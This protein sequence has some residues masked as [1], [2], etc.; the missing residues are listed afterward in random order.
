M[1]KF[2]MQANFICHYCKT[3]KIKE[4]ASVLEDGSCRVKT[5]GVPGE[6]PS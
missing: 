6:I 1:V 4:E 3:A 5:D 2:V